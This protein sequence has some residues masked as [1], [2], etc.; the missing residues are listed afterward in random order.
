VQGRI[1]ADTLRLGAAGLGVGLAAA[2]AL[3]RGLRGLLFGVTAADPATF[4]AALLVLG[5]A[6]ALA[7]YL[8]ARRA[9]RLSP[10]TAL[11]TE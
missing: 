9:A 10:V 5:G 4:A 11:R 8:P 7:G 3:A 1:L 6:A 2:W